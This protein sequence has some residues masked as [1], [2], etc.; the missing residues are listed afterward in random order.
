MGVSED[1]R[2]AGHDGSAARPVECLGDPEAP[3]HRAL[4]AEVG[5][6]LGGVPLRSGKR[7]DRLRLSHRVDTVLLRR[8][9]VLFFIHHDTRIVRIAG[10]TAKPFTDWVTQQARNICMELTEQASA[11]KFLIRDRDTKFSSSFDAVFATEGISII[12]IL[13]RAPRAN[14][15]AERFVGV[16]RREGLNGM[17]ILGRRHLEAVLAE[18]VE[19]YNRHR[20][21]RSIHQRSPSN[22][23]STPSE[24]REVDFT[25]LR[26]TDYLGGLIHEYRLVS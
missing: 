3:R 23:A 4:T 15:I 21:H 1:P 10:V 2:R 13:V 6:N 8:L 24:I 12:K 18:Y 14:G 19:H 22:A 5:T 16:V 11:V 26:R 9:Y 7:F 25:K 20:P 17:L